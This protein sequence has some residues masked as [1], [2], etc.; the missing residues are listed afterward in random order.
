MILKKIKSPIPFDMNF[1]MRYWWSGVF[2]VA[3][4]VYLYSLDGLY[5]PHIG[6]EAPY[7]EIVRL[8]AENGKWLPLKTVEGLENTKPPM[9]FWQGILSTNWAREWSLFRLRF[10][11]IFYTFLTTGLVFLLASKISGNRE[12]GY[13]GAL[14]YLGFYTTFLYGRPFLT[15]LPETFFVFLPFFL[16]IYFRDRIET[17]G[18]P[19]WL[20]VGLSIGV[21]CLYKSFVLVVPVGFALSWLLLV[22]RDW[23][24]K[25]F[26]KK[27]LYKV[28]IVLLLS[29]ICFSLWPLLDPDPKSIFEHFIVGENLGKFRKGNYIVEMFTGPSAIYRIWLGNVTNAGLL[30]LPVIYIIIISFRHRARLSTEEKALWILIFSFIIV[31]TAPG[32]RSGSYILPTMPAVAVLLGVRWMEIK[33]RWFFLFN[34]P[35]ILILLLLTML[36]LATAYQ[37]LPTKS[38]QSWQVI[39]PLLALLLGAGSFLINRISPYTFHLL[40][41]LIFG[42]L[43]CALAPF[44]GPLGRYNADTVTALKGR[45]V[46]I[47]SNFRSV[48]E[49]HRFILPGARTYGYNPSDKG[50][51]DELLQS[52]EIVAVNRPLGQPIVGP[53]RVFGKRLDLKSRHPKDEIFKIVFQQQLD[54]LI[55]QEIIVQRLEEMSK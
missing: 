13:L 41:F 12:S 32:Q 15:N 47:P 55:Q 37:A 22:K 24:L 29:L 49:L 18:I 20:L 52:G 10:P 54:L 30:A 50:R 31:Y 6:D 9:L 35:V 3:I 19:F 40:I 2:I 39:F 16:I 42:S 53:Y 11:I 45:T 5:V 14:S 44:H 1:R 4:F 27:D 17:W 26:I 38:Y 51:M 34:I 43:A 36:I 46:Y 8:T 25:T 33:S 28:I 7:I 23:E 48:Y 21:A